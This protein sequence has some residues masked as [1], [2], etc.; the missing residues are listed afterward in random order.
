MSPIH[1]IVVTIDGAAGTGKTSVAHEL[2]SRL[3]I[4]C[5]DTGAMYRA[6]AVIA[7]DQGVDPSDGTTLAN[8]VNEKGI[9]FAVVKVTLW[10]Y[11]VQLLN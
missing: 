1:Q 6:V 11:A 2:A 3:G 4:D 9:Q 8:M 7:V 10:L 5:L